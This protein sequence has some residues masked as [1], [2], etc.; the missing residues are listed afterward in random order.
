MTPEA[1]AKITKGIKTTEFWVTMVAGVLV[2]V[3]VY[4]QDQSANVLPVDLSMKLMTWLGVAYVICR[5]ALKI[6]GVVVTLMRID[7]GEAPPMPLPPAGVKLPEVPIPNLP[8]QR[9]P[10]TALRAQEIDDQERAD[11]EM[12][13][14]LLAANA[15]AGG[16]PPPYAPKPPPVV[17]STRPA[18]AGPSNDKLEHLGEY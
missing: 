2:T 4:L 9:V 3:M 1:K 15:A 12:K 5:T 10:W 7:R 18:G 16:A 14:R 17:H 8:G 13:Q 11:A 6:V